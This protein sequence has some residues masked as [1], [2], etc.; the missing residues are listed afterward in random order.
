M[1]KYKCIESLYVNSYDDDGMWDES[2][3]CIREHSVWQVEESSRMHVAGKSGIRL[4][5][6]KDKHNSEW[7]EVYQD[8]LNSHFVKVT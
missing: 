1:T 7:I 3:M 5:R 4:S 2:Y 8:T 6:M